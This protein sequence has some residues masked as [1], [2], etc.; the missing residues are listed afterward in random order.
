V[1]LKLIEA[2][3]PA[4]L[5]PRLAT[6]APAERL[7]ATNDGVGTDTSPGESA[8]VAASGPARRPVAPRVP[9]VPRPAS[10]RQIPFRP[11]DRLRSPPPAKTAR[12]RPFTQ[13]P[14]RGVPAQKC[15]IAVN[16]GDLPSVPEQ[17]QSVM[18]LPDANW[19][20]GCSRATGGP[21][22]CRG[23]EAVFPAAPEA[24]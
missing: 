2:D 6:A 23:S 17:R 19:R 7:E 15:Q 22:A 10:Q 9:R 8:S 13:I 24:C 1:L 12:F 3:A 16:K 21:G 14:K 20:P 11:A 18:P 4:K 5:L